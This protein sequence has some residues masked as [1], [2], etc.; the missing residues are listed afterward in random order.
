MLTRRMLMPLSW[1]SG[2]AIG[3]NYD[4]AT[5]MLHMLKDR[6]HL[7]HD[8]LHRLIDFDW[9]TFEGVEFD[10]W[11]LFLKERGMYVPIF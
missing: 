1:A 11:E 5:R 7:E 6:Y 10:G 9:R 4:R 3:E 2:C 8:L